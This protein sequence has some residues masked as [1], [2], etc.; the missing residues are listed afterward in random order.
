M[1]L[2]V[3]NKVKV[4]DQGQGHIKVKEKY[5]YPFQ[6]NVA[7]TVSKRVVCIGLKCIPVSY[8]AVVAMGFGTISFISTINDEYS[9]RKNRDHMESRYFGFNY[10][11]GWS[12][13]VFLPSGFVF[14]TS[15][16]ISNVV[17][18]GKRYKTLIKRSKVQNKDLTLVSQL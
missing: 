7:H 15:A 10:E 2:W 9:L 4:T 8:F 6:F 5:P 3:I 16:S 1:W 11:Y 13:L 18:H 14:A 17:I 12:S